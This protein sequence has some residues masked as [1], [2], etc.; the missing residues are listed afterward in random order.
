LER[1]RKRFDKIA[2]QLGIVKQEDW[3]G[4]NT[5]VVKNMGGQGLLHEHK[6]S[7][8]HSLQSIYPEFRWNPF[9][10]DKVS[11][12]FWKKHE[13]RRYFLDWLGEELGIEDQR[14]WY[15]ISS[16]QIRKKYVSFL[17]HYNSYY[18]ALRSIYSEYEWNPLL[19]VRSPN[20]YIEIM[21]PQSIKDTLNDELESGGRKRWKRLTS[22][23]YVTPSFTVNVFVKVNT[24]QIDYFNGFL[25]SLEDTRRLYKGSILEIV[26]L[27]YLERAKAN[28]L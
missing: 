6:D 9:L 8:I 28:S 27:A 3:Y 17:N 25:E 5:N 1:Y 2:E 13:N 12:N 24:L 15:S 11:S 14:A 19:F 26:G 4:V 22:S 20:N 21:K 18:H 7:L 10:R 23:R 16:S